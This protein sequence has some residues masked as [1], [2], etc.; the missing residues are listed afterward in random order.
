MKQ[1]ILSTASLAQSWLADDLLPL[2]HSESRV[3]ILTCIREEF[4][5]IGESLEASTQK[6]IA[7]SLFYYGVPKNQMCFCR[8]FEQNISKIRHA[9]ENCDVVIFVG[10]DALL[11]HHRLLD[12]DL[13]AD[14]QR[15]KGTEILIG[16]MA[17]LFIGNSQFYPLKSDIQNISGLDVLFHYVESEESLRAILNVLEDQAYAVIALKESAGF[18]YEEGELIPLG[19]AYLFQPSQIDELYEAYLTYQEN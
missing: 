11:A 7:R 1:I 4:H 3:L 5:V 18:I 19:D 12:F 14:I 15:Y 17:Y 6:E 8:L 10:N 13:M 16:P 9:L 2:L